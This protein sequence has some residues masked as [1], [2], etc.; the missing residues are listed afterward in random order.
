MSLGHRTSAIAIPSAF[1]HALIWRPAFIPAV[2]VPE[3]FAVFHENQ[4]SFNAA[5]SPA[6]TEN[7]S[8]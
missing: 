4:A 3:S 7:G 5:E 2:K 1:P 8:S 6:F